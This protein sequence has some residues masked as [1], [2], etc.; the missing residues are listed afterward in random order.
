MKVSSLEIEVL[1]PNVQMVRC[2]GATHYRVGNAIMESGLLA[3]NNGFGT[4]AGVD[5]IVVLTPAK[6]VNPT[7][8]LERL[9]NEIEA[10]VARGDIIVTG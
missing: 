3:S 8:M 9:M 2:P 10:A 4:L 6:G 5:D 7:D 1:G